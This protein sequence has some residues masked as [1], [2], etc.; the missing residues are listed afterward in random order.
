MAAA[1]AADFYLPKK[2]RD[3][4]KL[5]P[6]ACV[7]FIYVDV[8][9]CGL[10]WLTFLLSNDKKKPRRLSI[11]YTV[12]GITFEEKRSNTEKTQE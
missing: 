12:A 7:F 4:K 5:C 10:K 3:K 1:A 9:V 2:N 6:N 8:G 11:L